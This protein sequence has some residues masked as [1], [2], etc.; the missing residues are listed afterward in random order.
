MAKANVGVSILCW[1]KYEDSVACIDSL[2]QST[3][4]IRKIVVVDNASNDGSI[5][6]LKRKYINVKSIVFIENK[7]NLGF[8]SGMN[9]GIRALL[10]SHCE[11]ILPLN[12]DTVVASDMIDECLKA[13]SITPEMTIIGPRIY[14][15]NP[16]NKIWHGRAYWSPTKSGIVSPEKNRL[17]TQCDDIQTEVTFLSGC[18]I[19]VPSE[20]FQCVG[21]FDE[22]YYFYSEDLDYCYRAR[23]AGFRMLHVPSSKVWHNISGIA[24]DRTSDFVLYNLAKSHIIFLRKNFSTV[25]VAYGL[26][27]H[28][29]L[30]TPF[31]MLQIITGS[32]SLKSVLAWFKGTWD[33]LRMPLRPSSRD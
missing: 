11:Y 15:A 22:D 2:L 8:A 30:F 5:E 10:D 32:R 14:Y 16:S 18:A 21:L 26:L 25:Y 33:G 4:K 28:L 23:R 12:Q 27:V 29:L 3:H 19:L 13:M 1:K 7:D 24:E 9:I 6:R 17:D 31:R 20:V